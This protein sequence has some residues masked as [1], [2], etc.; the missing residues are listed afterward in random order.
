M[1]RL[2][3]LLMLMVL[4]G[5]CSTTRYAAYRVVTDPEGAHVTYIADGEYLGLSPT[6]TWWS[7]NDT[8]Q[9]I[10]HYIRVDKTGY[11]SV[12]GS[13]MVYP[14]YKTADKAK[15][16]VKDIFIH[17]QPLTYGGEK[18]R[19]V[20]VSS[21]PAGASVYGNQ[22]YLGTTPLELPVVFSDGIAQIELRFEKSGYG[23]QRRVLTVTDDKIHVVLHRI[24]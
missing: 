20:K 11:E 24:K 5:A 3:F 15:E 4:L 17:L 16:D 6:K 10:R 19:V 9:P 13:F 22:N 2:L 23:T 14:K 21:D 18:S 8:G 7:W 12:E 1:K